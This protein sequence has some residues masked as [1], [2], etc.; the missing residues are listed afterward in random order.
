MARTLGAAF[1]HLVAYSHA[2]ALDG[3]G[4]R[5]ALRQAATHHG[6]MAPDQVAVLRSIARRFF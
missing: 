1:A 4:A 2:T 6:D 5:A 3:R